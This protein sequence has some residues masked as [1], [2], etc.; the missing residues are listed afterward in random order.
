MATHKEHVTL[1]LIST[2]TIIGNTWIVVS[3]L[4]QR[5]GLN[6]N[7]I[8]WNYVGEALMQTK[9]AAIMG[10]TN[11]KGVIDSVQIYTCSPSLAKGI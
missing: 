1:F 5:Y 6:A 9:V 2:S 3:L 4:V 10:I 11:I 7:N 8:S